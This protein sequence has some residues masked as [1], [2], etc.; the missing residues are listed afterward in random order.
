MLK[1]KNQEKISN[2]KLRIKE[3]YLIING[4]KYK[5]VLSYIYILKSICKE[6]LFLFKLFYLILFIF[7]IIRKM[8]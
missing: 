6:Q 5:I 1:I 3:K 4:N 7:F 8:L 2:G